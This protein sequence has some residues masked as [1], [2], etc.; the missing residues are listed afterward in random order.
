MSESASRSPYFAPICLPAVETMGDRRVIPSELCEPKSRAVRICSL[1][2]G[3]ARVFLRG[4]R[5]GLDP[6]VKRGI[7]VSARD[8]GVTA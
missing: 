1:M 4:A 2:L 8:G 3:Y 5:R 6:K 7:G